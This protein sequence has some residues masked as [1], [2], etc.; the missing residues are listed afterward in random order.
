M[1]H[2]KAA[3]EQLEI[4]YTDY[5]QKR[6]LLDRALKATSRNERNIQ[7]KMTSLTVAV[8]ELNKCHTLWVSKGNISDEQLASPNQKFNSNWL[9]SAWEEND[10]YQQMG[11]QAMEDM[12]PAATE[13]HQIFILSE[14]LNSIKL[15]IST[16]V[17]SLLH[18]T[19]P[20][21]TLINHATM[22]AHEELLKGV[23]STFSSDLDTV[24]NELKEKDCTN[25][26]DHCTSLESF[27]RDIQSKILSVQLQLADQESSQQ[28]S[29]TSLPVA[30]RTHQRG[31][32]MEKSR[33][34]TFSGRTIDYPEF[35]RGWKKVAGVCWEDSNQV[36]QIKFKVDDESRRII[37]RCK[38]MD[39]VWKV[40]DSEFAQEQEVINAVDEELNKLLSYNC[41]VAEYIVK[42]RNHLPNL[43]AAL[44]AVGGLDHLQSP[45][46][47]NLLI[48]RFDDRTL[49]DWDYFR[50]KS[51]GPTYDRFMAF[52]ID[53]YDASKS[54]VARSRSAN[55]GDQAHSVN[56]ISSSECHRCLKWSAKD[57]V[58][59]CPGCGRGTGINENIHHCLEHCGVYMAMSAN[60]RADCL[61][62]AGWCPV[63]LMGTHQLSECNL[64]NDPRYL[65]GVDGCRKH[66]HKTL[67]GATTP[68]LAKVLTTFD[69]H[70]ATTNSE[71]ILLTAQ[72]ISACG[73]SINT[74][75]DNCATCSLITESSAKNLNLVGEKIKL[76]IS[77]VTN[78]K[79]KVV[80]SAVYYVPL[81]DKNNHTHQVRA[82]QVDSILEGL[83][84]PDLSAVKNFFSS[85]IQERWQEVTSRPTG[86]IDLLIG[87]D[88]LGIH[89]VDVELHNN[90]RVVSSRFGQGLILSGF[91]PL[92]KSSNPK[93]SK[94]VAAFRH[95]VNRVSI[96]PI[97]E[98]LESD[99]MGVVPPRRCG[100]CRNCKE[101][102]FKV[103]ALSL[104]EQYE[105]QVIETKINYDQTINQFVVSYPFTHDPS[106]L[107]NN[108][109]QVIKIAE[110]LEKR[111]SKLNL[112]DAF[113]KEFDKM[114]AYGALVE[115][116]DTELEQW[117]GPTHYVSLQHVLNEES[118]TT[119]LRIVTNSS[120]SDR[121]GISLNGIL[122]K[123][124]GTLSDQWD[125]LTRWRSYEKALCSDVTKAYYALK[126]GELEKQVRRVC[127]RYGNSSQRWNTYG[128]NTVSFGDRPAA[129][130][131]EIA[132][133]RT[134]EMNQSID[135][136]ASTRI[137]EDRYVDDLST[138]GS[139]LEVARFM[140]SETEEQFQHNGTISRI[141]SKGSLRLKVLVCSGETDLSKIS[142]LVKMCLESF[143]I[144]RVI[145]LSLASTCHWW[146]EKEKTTQ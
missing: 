110:R 117:D 146:R 34:P 93:M 111:L 49:H 127:W 100:N 61:E 21:K 128:F 22:K 141:L 97:Y 12:M 112:L 3:L 65:C 56:R 123:G 6:S 39:E 102:S 8:D 98:F 41:S 121:K 2:A 129:F 15:D 17:D 66:H 4:A 85:S 69:N 89:P 62:R 37:S 35:K 88:F 67:H 60:E 96:K 36:E 90:L 108:K 106:I 9:E 109:G 43:E 122:M 134:A 81:V 124:H 20:S 68:F 78:T 31:I 11:E 114:I 132:I 27:R 105:S 16:R 142:N 54:S 32:E 119:P 26:K 28:P 83:T 46:R 87:L 137:K 101:C 133:R 58:Y 125:V 7:N 130:F 57:K 139:P 50:S 73:V 144:H 95:K 71:D 126:T 103:H 33:A 120:L 99:N 94:D 138:G 64:K 23:Q 44:D 30:T 52:L 92:I 135:P 55:L 70:A 10:S 143:G 91:H 1:A 104:K 29:T 82:L 145:S 38:T 24:F 19:A 42:L 86:S 75:F 113:N 53:R 40:L 51:T 47:V 115:L 13:D 131:L 5:K 72:S 118:P 107:P 45:D 116:Q 80:D 79:G 77:T 25:L 14:R 74:L 18:A 76:D 63:H 84:S 59:T 48:S 136:L 140:G